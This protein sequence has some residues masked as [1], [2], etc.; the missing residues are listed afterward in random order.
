MADPGWDILIDELDVWQSAGE[1]AT[2]WWRDDDATRYTAQLKQL[3]Q[4]SRTHQIPLSLAVIPAHL[5]ASLVDY[6]KTRQY[7]DVLQHGYAHR[8]HADKGVKKIE[9]GGD[10]D[11]AE[12]MEE[13]GKGLNILKNAFGKQFIPVLVPPWNRIEARSYPALESA[14]LIGISSMW[15]RKQSHP[16]EELLQ[17][18]THLDPVN[19]PQD[20]GFIGE[21]DAIMQLYL[22]LLGRRARILDIDEPT[23]ILTHHLDQ[24][25][26]VWSFCDELF[27][28]LNR[29]PAASWLDAKSIWR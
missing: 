26:E 8:S 20:R 2:F 25:P 12:I 21:Q 9:I 6:L 24:T 22:H 10:R 15:A 3:D 14:G 17:A 29:H 18:N 19:W 11:I 7:F 1:N 5:D 16:T 23:G 28:R 13:L 27:E 4:L